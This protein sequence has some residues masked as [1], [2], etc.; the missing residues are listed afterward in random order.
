[1]QDRQDGPRRLSVALLTLGLTSLVASG[2]VWAAQSPSPPDAE[3][4]RPLTES[5]RIE[6]E[7]ASASQIDPTDV[8]GELTI[9]E[10][11]DGAR[12]GIDTG[13]SAAD[14]AGIL[15]GRPTIGAPRIAE[16][17]RLDG[18]LDDPVW[19]TAGR[20]TEF[21]QQRPLDGAPA[22][23]Q[24]D[25]Y[26]A[27]DSSNLYFG[28]HAHYSDVGLVRAN[29][30][31]RDQT[32]LDDRITLYFDTFLDQQRAFLFS[33]NGYG[34]QGDAIVAAADRGAGGGRGRSGGGGGPGGPAAGPT[35]A[36]A[37][38]GDPAWDA[39]FSSA[40]TLVEDGW[41]AEIAIPF[42]SL[43]YPQKG[44]NETHRWG[45]QV[46]RTIESKD[47]SDV[48]APIS[49]DVAG[50]LPQMGML[51]GM[52]GLSL[53]RNLEIM[54]TVTAVQVGS[55][56]TTTGQFIN[57]NTAEGGANIKYG[58]TSNMTLDFT[59]NPDFSQIETDRPQIEVNQRFSLFFPELRPFFL[60]GQ[61]I[62]EI[63][64]P[65]TLRHVQTRTIVDPQYGA[66]LTGKVGRTSLG[67]LFA[68]DEAPGKVDD[69][70]DPVFGK[71][72]QVMLA[73]VRY[74]LYS[75]SHLGVLFTDRE[76][77]DAHSR[78][79]AIDGSFRIGPTHSVGFIA[80][81][82]KHRD[83]AG[84]ERTGYKIDANIRRQARR[85]SY[86]LAHYEINPDFR[87][88][89]GFIQ[90]TDQKNTTANV[91]YRWWPES[92]IV[93]WGPR[94]NYRRNHDFDG[95]LQDEQTGIAVDARFARNIDVNASVSRDLE[96]FGGIDFWKTR[97][98]VGGNVRTSRRVSFGGQVNTGNEIFFV[99]NP[100]LGTG[101]DVELNLTLRPSSRL[102]SEVTLDTRQF[103]DV[104]DG[105]DEEILD[106]KIWR[107]FTTYQFTGRL[108]LRNILEYN[109]FD[110][111]LLANILGTYRVNAGTVFF[112]GYDARYDQGNRFDDQLF[113]D[114]SLLRTNHAIFTKLQYLFRF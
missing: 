71:T 32:M 31:D 99:D 4:A 56:E 81:G 58:I 74:D 44:A 105:V 77:L 3:T 79:A 29:R 2:G 73:R 15:T 83:L 35:G 24:T 20:I 27:Y 91:S 64:G 40:G 96:R 87:T 61:E 13:A 94:L 59:Y 75:E 69:R 49:R 104:R 88:D 43:R 111:R 76:L 14:A 46:V 66:K 53:S 95:V 11:A 57:D 98:I 78:L 72:A 50:F 100:F 85:L 38:T 86:F 84:V 9:G 8:T 67:L 7:A 42:K 1:M 55:R 52:T 28:L 41:T 107:T 82:V 68:N 93:N 51:E 10:A 60:E 37:P 16:G 12:S 34:V 23:E 26:V 45:F 17:P 70:D 36:V 18:R 103:I 80:T 63:A 102:Q 90:R 113:P 101:T 30:V 97:Y 109:T 54:P 112:V 89:V 108:V 106:V 47:E 5:S 62:F 25:V 22:S 48:W 65:P 39:L 19:Q 33:V 110:R 92:W 6:E 21:L 114:T